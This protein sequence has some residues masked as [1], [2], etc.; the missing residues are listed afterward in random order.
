MWVTCLSDCVFLDFLKYKKNCYKYQFYLCEPKT[1][2]VPDLYNNIKQMNTN[3]VIDKKSKTN[4]KKQTKVYFNSCQKCNWILDNIN[5]I[6]VCFDQQDII[7]NTT[8]MKNVS[9]AFI[10]FISLFSIIIV[11]L[12]QY[13]RIVVF[14]VCDIEIVMLNSCNF[15]SV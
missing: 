11:L 15:F 12:S 3:N 1:W 4:K 2:K 8:R 14:F 9:W 13:N 5:W 10:L 7:Y 6:T